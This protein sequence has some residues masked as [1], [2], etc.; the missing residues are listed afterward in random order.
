MNVREEA[1]QVRRARTS[2]DL[3]SQA[4]F[5][6]L[7]T[8][9]DVLD[10]V[11][12]GEGR[13]PLGLVTTL[14]EA[15]REA[16]VLYCHWKSNEALDRSAT[17]E[18]DLDLLVARQDEARFEEILYRLGFKKALQ[19]S[20]DQ[21]PGVFH[22]YGLDTVS[23]RLVHVHAHTQ[24]VLGDDMTKNFRLPI[25]EPYLRSG[26]QGPLFRIPSAE[27]EFAVFVIRMV[28]KHATWDAILTLQGSLSKSEQLE[29]ADLTNRSDLAKVR[30]VVREHLPFVEGDLWE[31][32]ASTIRPGCPAPTR[33]RVAGQ[34]Q[35]SLASCSRRA[36]SVDTSLRVWRRGRRWFA[37]HVLRSPAKPKR[38]EGGGAVIA[39]VGG[40]GAGKTTAVED[41]HRWLS[42]DFDTARAHLGKPPR[43]MVSVIARST[44]DMAR[45]F[46]RS[47]V[48]G[49]SVLGE[50]RSGPMRPRAYSRLVWEVLTARDRYRL[51][52]RVR[53][54]TN[55][56]GIAICDRYP[57]PQI[58]LM[59]GA[60]TGRMMAAAQ[61]GRLVRFLAEREQ[62][63][64]RE[65]LT[66]D[67]LIVLRVDPDVA[68]SRKRDEEDEAFVRPR[69][70][71]IWRLDWSG[72]RAVVVDAGSPRADVLREVRSVVWSRL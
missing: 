18:N 41:L 19:S 35:R 40:D 64:Y 4:P 70:E 47:T 50:W 49:E 69:S 9:I 65:I 2:S 38:L 6:G 60:V 33:I 7:G 27:F 44:W 17:G 12:D 5:P 63:Y 36:I 62:R 20:V 31:R 16:G 51:Y 25:E 55:N 29:L 39:L 66:P 72:T 46:R 15:L 28:L 53:R 58:T 21:L 52:R 56:G 67:V 30:R 71:E 37:K 68:V 8:A 11:G 13:A 22:A 14:C 42:R 34:L 24:L 32:C 10:A 45:R 23:G 57:L 59:D 43:S 3:G 1:G 26:V 61:G 48:S 54:F